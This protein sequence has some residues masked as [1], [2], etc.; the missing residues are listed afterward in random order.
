M[1]IYI[2]PR[3]GEFF[4]WAEL[5]VSNTAAIRGLDNTP[6]EDAQHRLI[7]L[8]THVLDPL[9]LAI[10]RAIRVTSGFRAPAVNEAVGGADHSQHKL[11][12][13]ADIKVEGMQAW[14]LAELVVELGLPFDQLVWYAPERG[15]HLHISF[16]KRRAPRGQML[17]APAGGGYTTWSPA[18][19]TP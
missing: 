1:G 8:V 6:P 5:M 4:S 12:E 13:A 17:H 9:R 3:P 10:R 19:R 18:R 15:G 16:T 11:G 2:N 7:D 14:E